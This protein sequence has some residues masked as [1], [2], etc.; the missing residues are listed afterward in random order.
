MN[1][2]ILSDTVLVDDGPP[3]AEIQGAL[4]KGTDSLIVWDVRHQIQL[5]VWNRFAKMLGKR[6]DAEGEYNRVS[7][8]CTL[9]DTLFVFD[10]MNMKV[11]SYLIPNNAPVGSVRNPKLNDFTGFIRVGGAFYFC[12]SIYYKASGQFNS[13]LFKLDSRGVISPTSL[14][15]ENLSPAIAANSRNVFV[16]LKTKNDALYIPLPFTNKLWVYDLSSGGISGFPLHLRLPDKLDFRAM[17]SFDESRKLLNK[18]EMVL[19]LFLL[20]RKLAVVSGMP[21]TNEDNSETDVKIRFFS[22]TGEPVEEYQVNKPGIVNVTDT[23]YTVLW[24]DPSGKNQQHP[25]RVS[26]VRLDAKRKRG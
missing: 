21:R 22:Y 19:N 23:T 20:E 5:F 7:A 1:P 6:G 2:H 14:T 16:P 15:T 11:T 13:I 10:R 3:L 17:K 26:V 12:T 18:T 8:L 25:Y 9:G 24:I 4:W